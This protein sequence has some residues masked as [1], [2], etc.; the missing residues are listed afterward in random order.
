M[1]IMDWKKLIKPTIGK[2]ILFFILMG[3]LNILIIMTSRV[4][5]GIILV[6]LPL[7]F[8]PIGT[9]PLLQYGQVPPVVEFSLVNFVID[10]I[11]WYLVAALLV[12]GLTKN[13]QK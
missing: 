9:G 7:G 4:F 13:K 1:I 8:L 10:I 2:I 3:G 6:G 11:F 12:F 5:D